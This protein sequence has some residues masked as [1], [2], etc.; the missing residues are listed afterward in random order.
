M[1]KN[2]ATNAEVGYYNV[3][4]RLVEMLGFIP[5]LLQSSLLP[6]LINSKKVSD[7]LYQSRLLNYYRLNFVFF[8]L[9]A[10][11][12]YFFS[13]WIILTLYK[14]E[15]APSAILLSIMTSRI[16]LANMGVARSSF[17][18]IESL[19]KFSMLTMIIG[20]IINIVLNYYWIPE[21]FAKGAVL[22]TIISF[23]VTTFVVDFFYSKTRP[24]AW[25][26]VKSMFTFYALK[27]D[28]LKEKK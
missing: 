17:I 5:M 12:I 9:T 28:F 16:V 24:N 10:V 20:T 21:Y 2:L 6:S 7:E 4:L 19:F 1:L 13:D 14:E 23:T 25:L 26:L 18:N 15:Y 22:S 8:L 11:P 27:V 3:S